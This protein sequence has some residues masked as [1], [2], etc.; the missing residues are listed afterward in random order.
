[1][2]RVTHYEPRSWTDGVKFV[3]AKGRVAYFI[4][5]DGLLANG[6]ADKAFFKKFYSTFKPT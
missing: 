5:M 3:L 4:D 6:K 2:G 1:M